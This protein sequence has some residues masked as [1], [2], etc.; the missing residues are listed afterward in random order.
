MK[1]VFLPEAAK[2]LMWFRRY[3]ELVFPA[4]ASLAIKQFN[5]MKQILR[6]HPFIGQPIEG[7][8]SRI[9]HIP[10]TPFSVIYRVR[11]DRIEVLTLF[12]N[13]SDPKTL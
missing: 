9:Y 12:D 13:R 2:S 1:L 3:Y 5:M 4:G 7:R 11:D 10:R 6:D 8:E